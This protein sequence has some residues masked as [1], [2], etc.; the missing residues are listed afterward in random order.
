MMMASHPGA[1]GD[2]LLA[3]HEPDLD[4][5]DWEAFRAQ[6]HRMLDESLDFIRDVRRRPVWRPMPPEVRGAFD[7][8]LPRSGQDLA[9]I[10]A[11]FR[12]LVEPFGPGNLHP[13]FMGWV[14]GAGTVQGI[15][16]EMLAGGLNANLGGRDHAPIEVERQILRW[17]R[18]LFGYPDQAGGLFVTGTSQAN[19]LALLV[20]RAKALGVESRRT[21][22][23]GRERLT[24]YP[25]LQTFAEAGFPEVDANVWVGLFAP[26]ALSPLAQQQMYYDVRDTLRE[27]DFHRRQLIERG[28]EPGMLGLTG[29][30][31]FIDEERRNRAEAV[32]ISGARAD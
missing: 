24:A 2:A 22:L 13:A 1:V 23:A 5:E 16:A 11:E 21:G 20:A 8:P 14:H 29:F 31:R 18:T 19:F 15:L 7:A 30:G 26:V 27:P 28:Y 32:R 4:P 6:A 10:D 17:M 9:E 12:S 3:A 25:A